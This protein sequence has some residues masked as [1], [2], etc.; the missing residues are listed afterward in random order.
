MNQQKAEASLDSTH[1]KLIPME[2]NPHILVID[3]EHVLLDLFEKVL[4]KL[5]FRV[6]LVDNGRD[7]INLIRKSTPDVVLLDINM[8]GLDGISVLKQIKEQD[9]DIEVIIITGYASLD[10]AIEALKYGAFDYVK[11]PFSSLIP[12]VDAIR[13]AWE[14]RKPL[15]EGRNLKIGQERKIF[16]LKTLYN[17]SRMIGTCLNRKEIIEQVLDSLSKL[18]NYDLAIS[19]LISDTSYTGNT[20][21]SRGRIAAEL[22]EMVLQVVNPSS[23]ALIEEAKYNLIDSF[24]SASKSKT[25]KDT[26]FAS[27]LGKENI[28]S[29]D[30]DQKDQITG[31]IKQDSLCS[32]K[33]ARKLKSF[34]NVPM[35]DDGDIRGMIHLGSHCE[36]AFD[37]DDI[38]LV[39]TV[40]SQVP[41]AI[42]RINKLSP[43][44]GGTS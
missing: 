41:L 40:V 1:S 15:L 39:Y 8:P 16:E 43:N 27:I 10:S 32:S 35:M 30:L 7:A 25:S 37:P 5:G 23:S 29:V 20:T 24:N 21:G 36:R 14:R 9:P 34:L 11:K 19:I 3:D 17:I 26:I 42:N 4:K 28:K 22:K 18:I 12:V 44:R 2:K 33:I 31:S 13:Q 38:R 6:A